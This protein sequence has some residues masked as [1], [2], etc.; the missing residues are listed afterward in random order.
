METEKIELNKN[1]DMEQQDKMKI[2]DENGKERMADVLLYFTLK[3]NNKDYIIYTFNEKDSKGMIV[4]YSSLINIDPE[5]KDN[6]TL[7]GIESDEEWNKIKDIMRKLIKT[8][9]E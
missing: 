3:E 6:V 1:T 5:N 9:G 7:S 8:S 4:V 2:I